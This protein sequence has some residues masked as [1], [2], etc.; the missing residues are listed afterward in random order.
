MMNDGCMCVEFYI[1]S[2]YNLLLCNYEKIWAAS[3]PSLRSSC[4]VGELD[5]GVN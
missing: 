4:T 5:Y 1:G 3:K 2:L